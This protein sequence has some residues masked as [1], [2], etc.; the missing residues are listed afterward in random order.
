MGEGDA[1]VAPTATN[2]LGMTYKRIFMVKGPGVGCE[3]RSD[4]GVRFDPSI[5]RHAQDIASS[6]QRRLNELR[7]EAGEVLELV[8]RPGRGQ[9][10]RAGVLSG[11]VWGLHA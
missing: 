4:L 7:G 3:G 6:R 8:E 10:G 2:R 5:L 1:C 9:R 11:F